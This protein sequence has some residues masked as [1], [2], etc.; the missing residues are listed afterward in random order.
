M[1]ILFIIMSVG[2]AMGLGLAAGAPAARAATTPP[3]TLYVSPAGTDSSR[4]TV[5]IARAR[6]WLEPS[7]ST[8]Y[9][10]IKRP[11]I[12]EKGLTLKENERTLC[13]EVD[14]KASKQ[15][16]QEAVERLFKVK[17]QQVRTMVVPGKMRR[18]GKYSGYRSDWKKAYVTLREG[19]KMIE[20][21]ENM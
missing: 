14:D 12:T 15:Q 2:L 18:R 13:F 19:E 9:S 1:R 20:Y 4:E 11:I 21:G 16:I 5:A 3:C 6:G 17:V 8:V 10:V 7:Y